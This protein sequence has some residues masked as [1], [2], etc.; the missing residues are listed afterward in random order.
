MF[1]PSYQ[2]PSKK[3]NKIIRK[4]ETRNSSQ[5]KN[6]FR[7]KNEGGKVS[8]RIFFLENWVEM[9]HIFGEKRKLAKYYVKTGKQG[10]TLPNIL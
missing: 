7:S 8:E 1:S 4:N 5:Q 10:Q 2:I 6:L 3:N 9:R